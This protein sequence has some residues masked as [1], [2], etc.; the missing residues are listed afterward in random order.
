[1]IGETLPTNVSA[2]RLLSLFDKSAPVPPQRPAV[3]IQV[4]EFKENLI[5]GRR[6]A[7]VMSM[8]GKHTTISASSRDVHF[9]QASRAAAMNRL[10]AATKII[11]ME[12]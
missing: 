3:T 7:N 5:V 4:Q 9:V 12:S 8:Y 10:I 2:R 1:L 6:Q 11:E